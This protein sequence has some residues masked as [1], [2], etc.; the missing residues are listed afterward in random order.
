MAQAVV[1]VEGPVVAVITATKD[2]MEAE[3]AVQ[4]QGIMAVE[5]VAAAKDMVDMMDIARNTNF[6]L[7]Y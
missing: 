7:N 1:L 4:A 2:I 3:L 6:K 5:V